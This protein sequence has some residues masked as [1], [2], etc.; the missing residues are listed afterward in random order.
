MSGGDRNWVKVE[1][2]MGFCR[3]ASNA[4]RLHICCSGMS[5]DVSL[6]LSGRIRAK[7]RQITFPVWKQ[8]AMVNRCCHYCE[9]VV[10]FTDCPTFE[11]GN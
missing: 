9:N 2:L 10:N 5:G 8:R 11:R 3:M 1:G 4:G 7:S 6:T